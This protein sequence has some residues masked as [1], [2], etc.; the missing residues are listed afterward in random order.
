M[1]IC[2]VA[3]VFPSDDYSTRFFFNLR[4]RRL[5]LIIARMLNLAKDF[6]KWRHKKYQEKLA[7]EEEGGEV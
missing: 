6:A 2:A 7:A 3:E 1:L 4:Q 5:P